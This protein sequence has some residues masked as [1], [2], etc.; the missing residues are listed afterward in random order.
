MYT[1]FDSATPENL[2]DMGEIQLSK[3]LELYC[4]RLVHYLCQKHG[5]V[6][7]ASLCSIGAPHDGMI[8]FC[9]RL[10]CNASDPWEGETLSLKV[11]LIDA[12]ENWEMLTGG[13]VPCPLVFDPDD[14][15]KTRKLDKEQREADKTLETCRALIGYGPEGWVP[16][17]YYEEAMA[18]TNQL[19]EYGFEEAKLGEEWVHIEAHWPFGASAIYFCTV[20]T[21]ARPTGSIQ[22]AR[23]HLATE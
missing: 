3:E 11:V 16:I 4:R 13:C 12:K 1:A 10:F 23:I 21:G 5:K 7:Q 2:D 20:C 14:V 15:H 19:K 8:L 18:C 17:E 22:A 9:Q 6:Q